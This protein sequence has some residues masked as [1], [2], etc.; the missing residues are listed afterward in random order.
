MPT[1]IKVSIVAIFINSNSSFGFQEYDKIIEV[2]DK[3]LDAINAQNAKEFVELFSPELK[4]E[5]NEQIASK[6]ICNLINLRGKIQKLESVRVIGD[7]ARFVLVCE[8]G[9]WVMDLVFNPNGHITGID[10]KEPNPVPPVVKRNFM[11]LILPFHG[12]W[13]VTAGGATKEDNYHFVE[14][15]NDTC[16]AVDFSI[17]GFNNKVFKGLGVENE[18]FFS[19]GQEIL[20]VAAGQVVTVIEGVPDNRPG[21]INPWANAGNVVV[22]RHAANE[23][24]VYCHLKFASIKVL[25]GQQ[26]VAGQVIGACG[27]SGYSLGPHLH[28]QM[29]NSQVPEDATGFAPYFRNIRVFRDKVVSDLEEHTPLRLDRVSN[30]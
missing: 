24:S 30:K 17:F 3:V 21:T 25:L 6:E 28:F 16:R 7:N 12:E 9:R 4:K 8:R 13:F 20:S 5:K 29:M 14:G 27:N 10:I 15:G 1:L 23:Y 18:D 22:I 2:C 26:V 11:P 19:F